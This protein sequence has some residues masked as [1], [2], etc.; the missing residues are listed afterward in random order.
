[1]VQSIFTVECSEEGSNRR[2]AE[3]LILSHWNDF[4]Q[5]AED[6]TQISLPEILFF[7]SGCKILPPEE[8]VGQIHFL[9][10]AEKDGKLSKFPKANT[11]MCILKLPV[12]HV[13]YKSF[14]NAMVFGIKNARGF[15]C[16]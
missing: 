2:N 15:G 11:C 10:E 14:E 5:D 6:P 9:H 12:V 3:S 4:L 7:A 1:M 8:L 13:D 16:A